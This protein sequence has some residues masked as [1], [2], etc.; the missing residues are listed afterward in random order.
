MI[1]RDSRFVLSFNGEITNYVE[2]R[3]E[4]Q[5]LG[6][7]FAS[8]SDTEVLL[9]S[10]QRWGQDSVGKFEG[11]FAF[12]IFDRQ[13]NELVLA[14]DVFGVK[15]LFYF[16]T[17]QEIFFASELQAINL[18]R[19]DK[20]QINQQAAF[21]FLHWG[22]YDASDATFIEGVKQ[23]RPGSLLRFDLNQGKLIETLQ[24]W[25]PSIDSS[26]S[27]TFD[28]ATSRVR[29][30]LIRSVKRN[31][32]TDVPLGVALS[33]G[34]DS[35][36]ITSIVRRLEPTMEIN[37]FS[38]VT[39]GFEKSEHHWVDL[40]NTEFECIP[41]LVA[42]LT[43]DL[44]DDLDEMIL[45]QG[46]PF[47]STSIYAQYR[48]FQLAKASGVTV[49]LD[50]QGAD[51]LFAGYHG[52][53]VHVVRDSLRRKHPLSALRFIQNW[54]SWPGRDVR[55]V[56]LPI[57]ASFLPQ[58]LKSFSRPAAFDDAESSLFLDDSNTLL[59]LRKSLS[60]PDSPAR[61]ESYLKTELRRQLT[62]DG[63]PALLRH[64]DRNSM[65]FSVESRVPFLD[66]ELVEYV[67]SLPEEYLVSE[68]GETKHVL[69][70]A[71]QGIA[72][73]VVLR[74]R[75]KIGFETPESL[76]LM[77]YIT[78]H[79]SSLLKSVEKFDFLASQGVKAFLLNP[80]YPDSRLLW[81]LI[82]LLKWA[83]LVSSEA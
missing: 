22:R 70:A 49:T 2:I 39:P 23:V 38:F 74:R 27:D 20:P 9:Q 62:R 15:P 59:R 48:V 25:I 42:P 32:R 12:A 24:Y 80:D 28:D 58:R 61:G 55:S 41:H 77:P 34:L 50:G 40:V 14:R 37:T 10:W 1:S 54:A 13:S 73:E 51:E 4:L 29:E 65:H 68:K 46:E 3:R 21:D 36:A 60:I 33:G 47:G 26:V 43:S 53:P 16:A 31:L 76:W 52:F 79:R 30:L 78:R 56:R 19:P 7:T 71:L 64:A 63:L 18:L 75:D 69:R 83:E 35:T 6:H 17:A 45:A 72:P 81:R 57:I 11:M 67:L 8:E 44:S 5:D 82:N 66:K